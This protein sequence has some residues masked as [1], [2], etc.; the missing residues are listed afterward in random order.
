M[1]FLSSILLLTSNSEPDLP[2]NRMHSSENTGRS[3]FL[4]NWNQVLHQLQIKIESKYGKLPCIMQSNISMK[5][6]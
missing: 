5:V 6:E 4:H 1:Q 2:V 3:S